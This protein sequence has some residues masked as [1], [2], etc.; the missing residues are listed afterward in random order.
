MDCYDEFPVSTIVYNAIT[1]G[2]ALVVG[3]VVAAQFGLGVLVGYVLLLIL[4][5]GGIITTICSRCASYYGRR[6][7]T[8]FGLLAS[9]LA[10]KGDPREYFRTVPQFVYLALLG[11]AMLSPIIGAVVLFVN[12]F[13][14][15]YL[16]QAI[17]LVGLLLAGAIPHPRLVC[18]HCRQGE[19]GACPVGR[20][21]HQVQGD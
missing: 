12:H 2:G 10:K 6:C 15:A 13:S 8:G 1:I 3:A 16:V 18:R 21:I 4:A 14:V 11:I 19:C 9:M 20:I 17:L 5:F 7:A